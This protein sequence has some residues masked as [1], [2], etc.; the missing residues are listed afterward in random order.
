MVDRVNGYIQQGIWVEKDVKVV[1]IT[2]TGTTYLTDLVTTTEG[3][4]D[5]GELAVAV[6]S[7]LEVAAEK[8]ATRG[9]LLGINVTSDTV[10]EFLVGY[11]GAFTPGN[12]EATANSVELEVTDAIIAD[13]GAT[14]CAIAVSEGFALGT[15]G[16]PA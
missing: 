3:S 11:A 5:A 1:Q 9:T 14:D 6:N 2:A 10:V 4:P 13:S 16:T 7:D 8:I 15:P 12:T